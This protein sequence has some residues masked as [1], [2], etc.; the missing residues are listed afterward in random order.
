M[1]SPSITGLD[2]DPTTISNKLDLILAQIATLNKHLDAHER[3]IAGVE[4]VLGVMY[5]L[6]VSPTRHP[7]PVTPP[8]KGHRC[9]DFGNPITNFANTSI[10]NT[11]DRPY[12]N[13]GGHGAFVIAS[14]NHITDPFHLPTVQLSRAG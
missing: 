14:T 8:A 1:T 11:G 3:H 4:H 12:T 10:I 9:N 7:Y 2:T 6:L 5:G 13:I